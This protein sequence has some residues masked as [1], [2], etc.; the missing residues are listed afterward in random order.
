[1]KRNTPFSSAARAPR[2]LIL[3]SSLLLLPVLC[4]AQQPTER[5]GGFFHIVFSNYRASFTGLPTVPSCCPQYDDGGGVGIWTGLLYEDAF[6][7]QLLFQARLG[8]VNVGGSLD[9]D[10]TTVVSV[11]GFA[12]PGVIRHTIDARLWELEFMP[13]LVY[14][15][16]PKLSFLA[17]AS[18]AYLFTRRY[19]QREALVEPATGSFE[20]GQRDRNVSEGEIPD[21]RTAQFSLVAGLRYDFPFHAQRRWWGAL[22]FFATAGLTPIVNDLDWHINTIRL[23]IAVM[24]AGNAPDP[25][26]RVPEAVQPPP[27]RKATAPRSGDIPRAEQP[28]TRGETSG[29]AVSTTR[30]DVRGE[31]IVA[32]ALR[33]LLNYVFFDHQS[34]VLDTRYV[35]LSPELARQFRV[36]DLHRAGTMRIYYHVLNIVGR[37][38]TDHPAATI[39][40]VGCNSNTAEERDNL[41]LSLLRALA[42]R[43]YLATVWHIDTA[44]MRLESRNLPEHPSYPTDSDGIVENRRVEIQSTDWDILAPVETEEIVQRFEPDT[45]HCAIPESDPGVRNWTISIRDSSGVVYRKR[46]N[47]APPA[48]LAIP[49]RGVVP[50]D[51]VSGQTFRISLAT[52][53]ASGASRS[54]M[55]GSFA[56]ASSTSTVEQ[57]ELRSGRKVQIFN[58]ILFEFDSPELT[59]YHRRVIEIIK[60]RMAPL[61]EVRI[62]GYTDRMGEAEYNRRL[63]EGRARSASEALKKPGVR[64]EGAG[65]TRMFDNDLPE[66]RC[67]NRTVEV[68]VVGRRA[69]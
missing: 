50:G 4:R 66:G 69:E 67:Y 58:L 36:N 20:N 45:V 52:E 38:L 49:S 56:V 6:A 62:T 46:G 32:D 14:K 35:A 61:S 47:G 16:F 34:A 44:R 55:I 7:S 3:L 57:Y 68:E 64:F 15:P 63:S 13:L 59:G 40:L 10:E 31:R 8:V 18:G 48:S 25:A 29:I 30:Y 9:A 41:P 65:E 43:R 54:A 33:P 1:M 5:F 21:V 17:G 23:G 27:Q 19:A 11:D 26:G 51:A 22:E 24:Y 2:G 53:T 42:V 39:T 28:E 12:T 37:R 60:K